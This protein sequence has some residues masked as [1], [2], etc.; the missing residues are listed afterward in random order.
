MGVKGL[1]RILQE[2]QEDVP[3]EQLRNSVLA[4]DASGWVVNMGLR[5]FFYRVRNLVRAGIVPLVVLDGRVPQEKLSVVAERRWKTLRYKA[6]RLSYAQ[7]KKMHE[8]PCT[9]RP[10]AALTQ[11]LK[12]L[13]A[14]VIRSEG[15]AE[16]L[17][18]WLDQRGVVDGVISG[19]SDALLYGAGTVYR[20]VCT[21]PGGVCKRIQSRDVRAWC[22]LSR[23]SLIGVAALL[24]CDFLPAGVRGVGLTKALKLLR[25][26]DPRNKRDLREFLKPFFQGQD[27][28]HLNLVLDEFLTPPALWD[29]VHTEM[30]EPDIYAFAEVTNRQ[31]GWSPKQ[32]LIA[33][34]PV[35]IR[36]H[37]EGE[38]TRGVEITPVSSKGISTTCAEGRGLRS[39]KSDEFDPEE[40]SIRVIAKLEGEDS[41]KSNCHTAKA[42]GTL[43]EVEA[44]KESEIPSCLTVFWRLRSH[45]IEV[46]VR[47]VEALES[48]LIVYAVKRIENV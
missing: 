3:L 33:I 25:Q 37:L 18:A 19:D 17:C 40:Q 35:L 10:T 21:R 8:D 38:E 34:A 46:R 5:S 15:E 4:L 47:T 31:W 20:Q 16:K 30:L 12:G 23:W 44:G 1:W 22:G 11:V 45:G 2:A 26:A 7:R 27:R 42:E 6:R 29:F 9:I 43:A 14:P 13:G 36:W 32:S 39:G 24:G 28:K 48:I 41:E